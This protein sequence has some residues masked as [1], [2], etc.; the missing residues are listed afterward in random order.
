MAA[1]AILQC[2]FGDFKESF[3]V[4]E[5]IH[6]KLLVMSTLHRVRL[7]IVRRTNPNK[8]DI[9]GTFLKQPRRDDYNF[10]VREEI[11]TE[12]WILE[13]L[14]E[15]AE[16]CLYSL[17]KHL[18]NKKKKTMAIDNIRNAYKMFCDEE[19]SCR[20]IYYNICQ[21]IYSYQEEILR[22]KKEELISQKI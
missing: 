1:F 17:E 12:E 6:E 18:N 9:S 2:S 14:V 16:N 4:S 11:Y 10:I 8:E 13:P 5:G 3:F 21:C 20:D 19:M 7:E 22:E 15:Y